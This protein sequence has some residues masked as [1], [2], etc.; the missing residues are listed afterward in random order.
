MTAELFSRLPNEFHPGNWGGTYEHVLPYLQK[1]FGEAVDA[2]AET[3][4]ADVR[5]SLVALIKELCNPD[6]SKRGH[7]RGVGTGQ[8]YNLVR[9]TSQLTS[10]SMRYDLASKIK[11]ADCQFRLR[12]AS[13]R[14]VSSRHTGLAVC[15][16][17]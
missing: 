7:P 2:L 6:L 15:C 1:A 11:E 8:Q 17:T 16:G 10:L 14:E 5:V 12:L 9:Y 13:R 4:D 3:I